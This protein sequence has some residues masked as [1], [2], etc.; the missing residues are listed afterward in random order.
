MTFKVPAKSAQL[1][2]HM[3]RSLQPLYESPATVGAG[4]SIAISPAT[5]PPAQTPSFA[6]DLSSCTSMSTT[7]CVQNADGSRSYTLTTASESVGTYNIQIATWDVVPAFGAFPA[8]T[9]HEL[10]DA[11]TSAAI[12]AT[13]TTIN[14]TLNGI[15]STV[16]AQPLAGQTHVHIDTSGSGYDLIGNVP[17][18]WA[19]TALDNDGYIIAGSGQ[20]LF[21]YTINNNSVSV[22]NTAQ[23]N[24]VAIAGV[25][26]QASPVP[27]SI[28][29]QGLGPSGVTSA[30]NQVYITPL[31]ELWVTAGPAGSGT[32]G[33]FGYQLIPDPQPPSGDYV[34]S[35]G[36]GPPGSCC[37]NAF[38]PTDFLTT[39]TENYGPIA[40]DSSGELWVYDAAANAGNGAIVSFTASNSGGA[41]TAGSV[42]ISTTGLDI[43][44]LA[45][46]AN[47]YLYAIDEAANALDVWKVVGA[48]PGSTPT[49]SVP[50]TAGNAQGVA[51][52]P[53]DGVY[54][55]GTGGIVVVADANGFDFYTNASGG[56]PVFI[57]NQS[58]GSNGY[59]AGFA[60]DSATMWG[61]T[62]TASPRVDVY[63]VT[64]GPT[65]TL[66]AS[67]GAYYQNNGPV[68]V[69]IAGYAFIAQ[70]QT[71]DGGQTDQ[72]LFSGSAVNYQYVSIGPGNTSVDY[73]GVVISP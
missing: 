24:I 33:I 13:N 72:Y 19:V 51:I 61:L 47:G 9:L 42:T 44:A 59:S 2:P 34:V 54:P 28:Q 68:A 7:P 22:A 18:Q 16:I 15:P 73:L 46:D 43:G 45:A 62:S 63:T 21:N 10:S 66:Q 40:Q 35:P 55:S 27:L 4:I 31:Q 32:T 37:W 50:I 30:T 48:T 65:I 25:T 53:N 64:A 17:T 6:F 11:A 12:S 69:G 29:A 20:P 67:T 5:P 26:A 41:P 8:G 58:V 1:R 23:A 39:A 49:F 38:L 57:V 3:K 60:S 14:V 71:L 56:A 70:G 52:I 36:Y